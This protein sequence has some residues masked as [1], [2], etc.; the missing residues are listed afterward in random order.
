MS[1][2]PFEFDRNLFVEILPISGSNPAALM[3]KELI[4]G[5]K[6]QPFQARRAIA[7][8]PYY[9]RMPNEKLLAVYEEL[10]GQGFESQTKYTFDPNFIL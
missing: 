8:M 7:Y 6:L 10:M 2:L 3:I 4:S 1:F 5:D 9:L